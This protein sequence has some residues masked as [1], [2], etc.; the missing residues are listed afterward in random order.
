[1]KYKKEPLE[2]SGAEQWYQELH[3]N[4]TPAGRVVCARDNTFAEWLA[5]GGTPEEAD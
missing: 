4:G 5:A 2:R 1:M 3:D